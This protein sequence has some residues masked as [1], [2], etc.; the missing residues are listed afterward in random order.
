MNSPQMYYVDKPEVRAAKEQ[1]RIFQSLLSGRATFDALIQATQELCR[2]APDDSD[3][4]VLVGDVEVVQV[5]FI[6]PHTLSFEGFKE[7]GQRTWIV[8]HFSQLNA[9]VVYH[10]KRGTSRIITGFS[11]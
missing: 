1:T 11:P 8:Q 9:R 7:D 4:M 6:E 10:P 3:V 5:R 2:L